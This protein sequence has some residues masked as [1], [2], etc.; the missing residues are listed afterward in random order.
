LDKVKPRKW[1][2]IGFLSPF[3][4]GEFADMVY[5]LMSNKTELEMDSIYCLFL[6]IPTLITA[7]FFW[8]IFVRAIIRIFKSIATTDK[9]KKAEAYIL[10]HFMVLF[11]ASCS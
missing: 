11:F 1:I 5:Q 6:S 2:F 9:V 3:I 4:L 7:M 8:T 10:I